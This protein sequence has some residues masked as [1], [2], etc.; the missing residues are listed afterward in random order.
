MKSVNKDIHQLAVCYFEGSISENDE[1]VLFEFVNKNQYNINLFRNWENEWTACHQPQENTL[2]LW[3]RLN[4]RITI[5][6]NSVSHFSSSVN[7][8][9]RNRIWYR[10][11]A[12]AAV[13]L[14]VCYSIISYKTFSEKTQ[15]ASFVFE[16]QCAERSRVTLPDGTKVWLNAATTLCCPNDY[17]KK[18]RTVNLSG[19]AYFEVKKNEDIPFIVYAKDYPL[20]VKGTKFNVTAY[21]EEK[22]LTAALLE[23]LLQFGNDEPGLMMHP[24]DVVTYDLSLNAKS[25]YSTDAKQFISWTEGR[26]EYDS[27]TFDELFRRLSRQY[28]VDIIFT[29]ERKTDKVLNISLN[30]GETIT[31]VLNALSLIIPMAIERDGRTL[32]ITF[33]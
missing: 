7:K 4:Y 2:L 6:P 18:S 27:I 1:H 10:V 16:T 22:V 31:D 12:V 5:Q 9:S 13:L 32:T 15:V 20:L 21:P 29:S 11:A 3:E 28:D 8:V 26:I 19:E 33:K 14:I 23:G 30:N 17:N 24:D 25:I